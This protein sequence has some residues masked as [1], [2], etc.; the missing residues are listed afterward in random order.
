VCSFITYSERAPAVNFS[1]GRKGNANGITAGELND[2][3]VIQSFNQGRF[4]FF[5]SAT[6]ST[7]IIAS[8]TPKLVVKYRISND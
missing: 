5:S 2:I 1:I 3:D 6:K 8:P 4:H 7:L